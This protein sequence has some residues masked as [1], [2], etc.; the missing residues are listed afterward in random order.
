MPACCLGGGGTLQVAEKLGSM[1]PNGI[2]F[3][4]DCIGEEVCR[5]CVR[6][7]WIPFGVV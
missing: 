1:L 5:V 7:C 4:D 3:G 2:L 6:E